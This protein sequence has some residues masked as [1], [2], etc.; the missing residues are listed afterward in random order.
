MIT[1][2][3]LRKVAE[4]YQMGTAGRIALQKAS[5]TIEALQAKPTL[6]ADALAALERIENEVKITP[7]VDQFVQDL[8]TI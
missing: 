6:D 3:E 8:D 5:D 7:L 2:E 1:P 4:S